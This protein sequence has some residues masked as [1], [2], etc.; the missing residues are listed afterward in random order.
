MVI[1]YLCDACWIHSCGLQG[2][3]ESVENIFVTKEEADKGIVCY[4]FLI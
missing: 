3:P 2:Y 4:E 1:Y